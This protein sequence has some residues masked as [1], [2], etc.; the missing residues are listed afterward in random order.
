MIA[1]VLRRNG[2]AANLAAGACFL[3]ASTLAAPGDLLVA[4]R[5]GSVSR[6]T[7]E[8]VK[9]TFV[10]VRE[11]VGGKGKLDVGGND[12]GY[13]SRKVTRAGGKTMFTF[14]PASESAVDVEFATLPVAH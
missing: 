4:D 1:L 12:P 2:A 14:G 10:P 7:L 11:S 13:P 3:A 8:Q 6:Y 9:S 5:S